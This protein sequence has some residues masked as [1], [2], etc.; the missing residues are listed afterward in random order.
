MLICHCHQVSD[1]QILS[2]AAEGARTVGQVGRRCRA[3]TCCG[4]CVS[5]VRDVLDSAHR[6]LPVATRPMNVDPSQI[7]E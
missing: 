2:Y 7:T 3:G 6:T 4:G 5:A 1:R